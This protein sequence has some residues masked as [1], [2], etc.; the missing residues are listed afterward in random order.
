[1][2]MRSARKRA[3]A[4]VLATGV[5]SLAMAFSSMADWNS[6]TTEGGIYQGAYDASKNGSLS[7]TLYDR[8]TI[9]EDKDPLPVT[10]GKI[11]L[12]QLADIEKEYTGI[13]VLPEVESAAPDAALSWDNLQDA[14][15][16]AKWQD[17]IL[18]KESELS[19]LIQTKDVDG[20]GKVKFD[21]LSQGIY[22]VYQKDGDHADGYQYLA[23]YL[24]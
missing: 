8:T 10:D 16:L 15:A 6:A 18:E 7:I 9:S 1:M 11:S 23:P 17:G 22:M 5:L 3:L 2:K 21:N 12:I 13:S 4:A 14:A 24:V 19:G 20:Q